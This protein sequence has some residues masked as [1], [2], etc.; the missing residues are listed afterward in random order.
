[1]HTNQV[2][3]VGTLSGG[4]TFY[5]SLSLALALAE[6]VR[7]E[8]GGVDLGTLFVDEGF[9]SLDPDVLDDVMHTLEGLREGGRTVGIVSHV[10]ELKSRVADRIEVHRSPRPHLHP[11]H[12]RLTGARARALTARTSATGAALGCLRHEDRREARSSGWPPCCTS[13][14]SG[15][16][17]SAGPGPRPGSASASPTRPTADTNRPMAY[18][19]GFYNLFLGIGAALGLVLWW[20]GHDTAGSALVLFTTGSMVAA[21][22]VLVT[23]GRHYLRAALTQGTLP[24]IGLVLTLLA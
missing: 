8:S 22:T 7:A 10:T 15:W 1:M 20:T 23:T 13:T 17:A 3:D 14:S 6:V 21:A 18:N 2:R 12:H 24:L 4:E 16:R 9:G 11:A 19:Q 5:V